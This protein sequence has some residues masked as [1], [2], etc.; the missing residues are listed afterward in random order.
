M[1]KKWNIDV[2]EGIVGKDTIC[3]YCKELIDKD[4]F[5]VNIIVKKSVSLVN[6]FR[7]F[8]YCNDTCFGKHI[9]HLTEGQ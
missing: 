1:F 4:D 7:E 5:M 3:D 6:N 8:Y 2:Y 9:P